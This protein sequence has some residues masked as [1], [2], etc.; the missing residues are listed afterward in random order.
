M[1]DTF[2]QKFSFHEKA[3]FTKKLKKRNLTKIV[4]I[5]ILHYKQILGEY[6]SSS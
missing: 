2:L 4:K 1:E 5:H 3:T 6:A